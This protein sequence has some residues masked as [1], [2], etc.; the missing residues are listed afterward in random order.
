MTIRRV[1]SATIGVVIGGTLWGMISITISDNPSALSGLM[2]FAFA[3]AGG[4]I[5]ARIGKGER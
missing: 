2:G 1:V 3:V 4:F 5:G